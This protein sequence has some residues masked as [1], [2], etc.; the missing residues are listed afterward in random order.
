MAL[1]IASLV[2]ETA[3]MGAHGVRLG[4]DSEPLI[5]GMRAIMAVGIASVPLAY[6]ILSRLLAIVES[7]RLGEPFVGTNAQRL[8]TIGWSLLGL[9]LLNIAVAAIAASVS[10]EANPLD[11]GWPRD[12]TGW[13]AVLLMFVLAEVFEQGARMREDLEGTV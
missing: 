7:V 2:A 3:V 10:S 8:R 9:Q 11:F 12:V 5:N 4:A 1:L 6:I 13:L